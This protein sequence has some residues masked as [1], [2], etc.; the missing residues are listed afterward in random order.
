MRLHVVAFVVAFLVTQ[1]ECICAAPHHAFQRLPM[2]PKKFS[3]SPLSN[4]YRLRLDENFVR[5]LYR[6]L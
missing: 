5:R 6:P 1:H 3:T 4:R 2:A